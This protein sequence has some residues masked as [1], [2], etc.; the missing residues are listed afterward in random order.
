MTGS[1]RYDIFLL[2]LWHGQQ[3]IPSIPLELLP[4]AFLD[5]DSPAIFPTIY[6]RRRSIWISIVITNIM[7]DTQQKLWIY[8]S[9]TSKN[10]S[11]SRSLTSERMYSHMKYPHRLVPGGCLSHFTTKGFNQII[12]KHDM[13]VL[14]LELKRCTDLA[15][16]TYIDL[17]KT[18]LVFKFT[19]RS[20]C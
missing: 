4:D 16:T 8:C 17:I 19:N 6:K 3:E 10:V 18:K 20:I 15:R 5:R 14:K 11:P 2:G 12:I 7:N 13:M 1:R 9:S